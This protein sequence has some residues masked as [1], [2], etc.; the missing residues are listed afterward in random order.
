MIAIEKP[1]VRN[2]N[3]DEERQRIAD[4]KY[5]GMQNKVVVWLAKTMP[6]GWAYDDLWATVYL[7]SFEAVERYDNSYNAKFSSFLHAHLRTMAVRELAKVWG[8]TRRPKFRNVECFSQLP[9]VALQT[10]KRNIETCDD[11]SMVDAVHFFDSIVS[12]NMQVKEL[13]ESL[14]EDSRKCLEDLCS[15]EDQEGLCKAFRS[16]RWR[17]LASAI[18]GIS[19]E[20]L[21]RFRDEIRMKAH[22]YV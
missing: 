10:S 9:A 5:G 15:I 3:A 4:R 8:A 19:V 13:S 21:E 16:F 12:A 1:D 14:S 22:L 2:W 7:W 20:R 17:K 11:L 6:A 18:S